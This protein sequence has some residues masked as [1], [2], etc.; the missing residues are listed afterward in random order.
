MAAVLCAGMGAWDRDRATGPLSVD[1]HLIVGM[2]RLGRTE[3]PVLFPDEASFLLK[4]NEI[5]ELAIH[6]PAGGICVFA[7]YWRETVSYPSPFA[8]GFRFA[9]CF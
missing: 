7:A 3:F 5:C 4:F 6:I 2:G 9:S 1:L 8:A